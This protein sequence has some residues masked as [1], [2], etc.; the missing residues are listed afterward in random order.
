[1][2]GGGCFWCVE[3]VFR[4]LDGVEDV[5]SGYAGGRAE[6]ADYR[7]VCSGMTDHAE[8]IR[9]RFQPHKISFGRL[10]KVFFSAAHDPTQLDRQGNDHGRQYRSVVFFKDDAQ[11][12]VAEAYVEHLNQAGVFRDPIVTRI[13]PLETFYRAE[14]YHQDYAARNPAQPYIAMVSMPKVDKTRKLFEDSLKN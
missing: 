10:L 3:A 4:Q 14:D 6:H 1:M 8:V 7:T 9:I 11:R 5:E 2:L 13:E 12:R